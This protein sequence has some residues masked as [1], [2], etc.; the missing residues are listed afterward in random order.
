MSHEL[1]KSQE[2]IILIIIIIIII[3]I[4]LIIIII[5]IIIIKVFIFQ[6]IK[7]RTVSYVTLKHNDNMGLQYLHKYASKSGAFFHP[8]FVLYLTINNYFPLFHSL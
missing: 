2:K 7:L 4:I 1:L 6:K 8:F 5:I 3:I